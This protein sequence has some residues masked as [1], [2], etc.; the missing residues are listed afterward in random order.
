MEVTDRPSGQRTDARPRKQPANARAEILEANELEL[1]ADRSLKLA[2]RYERDA[3]FMEDEEG[4]QIA[5]AL[6]DWR[7]Q[8]SLLFRELS[9][10]AERAESA[11]SK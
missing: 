2:E 11:R 5:L 6:A 8:R 1:L 4:R 9:A 3:E 10:K 7:R